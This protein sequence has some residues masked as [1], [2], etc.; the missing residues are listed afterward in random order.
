[1]TNKDNR[2]ADR[3]KTRVEKQVEKPVVETG[4]SRDF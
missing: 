3:L 1:M 4:E 2:L